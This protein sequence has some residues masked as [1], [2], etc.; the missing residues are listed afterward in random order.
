[1]YLISH[2]VNKFRNIEICDFYPEKGVNII[3]GRN[4]Q[5][6]TNL[7]ESIY[8]LCGARSFRTKCDA[9]LIKY[10]ET[11]SLL[12]SA[13][14]LSEREQKIDIFISKNGR[15]AQLNRGSKMKASS[16][17]GK[18][19]CVLFSPEHLMLIKGGP[20]ERRKFLDTALCQ[21]SARYLSELKKYLRVLKQKN[22]LLKEYYRV[23]DGDH[24]LDVLDFQLI[25]YS[26]IVTKIRREFCEV[27]KKLSKEYYG[28]ISGEREELSV[29]FNSSIWKDDVAECSSGMDIMRKN[30][31][32]DI[33]RGYCGFGPHR[34]DLSV[35]LDNKDARIFASQGQQRTA[36]LSMKM[37]EA[38]IMEKYLRE[39][40]VLLLDDV[41]SELDL[42]RRGYLL[43]SIEGFQSIITVCDTATVSD[44]SNYSVFEIEEGNL[45]RN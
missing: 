41:L 29:F 20:V 21:I 44:N 12:R 14:F 34:D 43:E 17:T 5:G 33:K 15:E 27:L 3:F 35:F 38:Q 11:E 39:K 37:S 26:L 16:L 45:I 4:G 10:G 18:F 6:K 31:E 24:I 32:L 23:P 28:L 13:F 9:D 7:L 1:L 8:L 2:K 25:E 30:R 36:V 22:A 19:C 40:P 42:S